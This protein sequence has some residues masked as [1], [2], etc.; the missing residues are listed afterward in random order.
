MVPVMA[1]KRPAKGR[2]TSKNLACWN[3]WSAEY[4]REYGGKLSRR[5]RAWG[6]WRVPEEELDVLGDVRGRDVLEYGCGAAQWS[7]ALA[8][9]GARPVAL[10]LSDVQLGHARHLMRRAGVD[11]PLVQASGE[12][13]PFA[14][15]SFDVVLCD[16]GAMTFGD[17]EKTVAEVARVLRA[18]GLFA[19]CQSS[20][21][22][23]LCWDHESDDIGP[24]M[25]RDYFGMRRIEDSIQVIYQLPYGAWIRLFR[26]HG[27][28]V[29]DLI[30]LRPPPRGRSFYPD[31]IDRA[32]ARRWPAENVWK[33]RKLDWGPRRR[34]SMHEPLHDE[35]G[36]EDAGDGDGHDQ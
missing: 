9:D 6:V 31:Y 17:P 19:F 11:V 10:D 32:W 35:S 16:H 12:D 14:A 24:R 29:E 13:V 21:L 23:D 25:V 22:R 8:L 18:G 27:F 30:E 7:I 26:R 5:P 4:Q 36:L 3:D 1:R 20:P 33:L 28:A 2:G 34:S 15:A